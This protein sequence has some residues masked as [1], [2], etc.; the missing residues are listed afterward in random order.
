MERLGYY[1]KDS[2]DNLFHFRWVTAVE[3]SKSKIE[4]LING[5]WFTKDPNDYEI[6]EIGFFTADS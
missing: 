1:A 4:I 2:K 6:L 5:A 3:L